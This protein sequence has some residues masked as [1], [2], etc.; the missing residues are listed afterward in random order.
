MLAALG[1]CQ[2][3]TKL[4]SYRVSEAKDA[5]TTMGSTSAREGVRADDDASQPEDSSTFLPTDAGPPCWLAEGAECDPVR[6]CG[7]SE[8]LHCQVRGRELRPRCV[9]AG[10]LPPWAAC[11]VDTQCPAGQTCD[12]GSCRSYCGEDGD[13]QGDT[14]LP[15]AG[16]A[17]IPLQDLKVCWK[18][19]SLEKPD[20]CA[21]G[22]TCRR[23]R[24]P[25]AGMD[26]FCVAP[27]D[28]CPTT[29]DGVCDEPEGK[30]SCAQ[31]TDTRD[32]DCVKK[33]TNAACDPVAQCGCALGFS[34]LAHSIDDNLSDDGT[35]TWT[36]EC[37]PA[38][39]GL[40]HEAC[41][42]STDCAQGLICVLS[43]CS[44]YCASDAD[45]G[46]GGCRPIRNRDDPRLGQC[47]PACNRTSGAP[48]APRTVCAHFD[49]QSE[50]LPKKVGDYCWVR[51]TAAGCFLDN[52]ICEEPRGSGLC[53]EG[54]DQQDCCPAPP[55]GGTCN[56]ILQCG[57]E[58]LPGT[59][60]QL[61]LQT[62]MTSC[63]PAGA[64][65]PWSACTSTQGQC[66][67]GYGCQFNVC[68]SYCAQSSDCGAGNV[69]FKLP[70]S[71]SST[72]LSHGV[73]LLAC[74]YTRPESCPE[75]LLCAQINPE[76]AT[77]WLPVTDCTSQV[78]DG[79]CDDTR[80]GGTRIC[81]AGTDP[82]CME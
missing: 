58:Q 2:A 69:C 56:P 23:T 20:I 51:D 27:Y 21:E 13:C 82:D 22:T 35:V 68:R 32:C 16:D 29:E 38:G 26:L 41:T 12:R 40:E 15:A 19:C 34:C 39:T 63:E 37:V 1:G 10:T 44:K 78:G 60:C 77:C 73:C 3:V 43:M 9:Y 62:G 7:C 66:P 30:G 18:R 74:D 61:D 28:P 50:W 11:N 24:T 36:A 48:C 25:W 72:G 75:G 42:S 65:P 64:Q 45:C 4:S 53:R 67:A 49:A 57:C 55:E 46:S 80:P 14:C 31:G 54:G 71:G 5:G 33:L 81:V 8:G 70:V 59:H 79:V 76:L 52:G 47:L 17:G 6:Q